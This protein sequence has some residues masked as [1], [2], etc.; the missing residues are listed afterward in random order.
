MFDW[1][2]STGVR[3]VFDW[4]CGVYIGHTVYLRVAA[5][6]GGELS[7]AHQKEW[8]CGFNLSLFFVFCFFVPLSDPLPLL[9]SLVLWSALFPPPPD[10]PDPPTL[11]TFVT[12]LFSI[13]LS[14]SLQESLFFLS[15]YSRNHKQQQQ[16]APTFI[17]TITSHTLM[18]TTPTIHS[19]YF[20]LS[21]RP[22]I[23][24][25]HISL[26]NHLAFICS[27]IDNFTL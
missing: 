2:C 13:H 3:L 17:I 5:E 12:S 6:W 16:T 27:L 15:F 8:F 22:S 19:L 10:P 21:P 18:Q 9:L 1:C 26:S 7:V 20:Y 4:F 11:P 23:Y 24:H 14:T 25:K